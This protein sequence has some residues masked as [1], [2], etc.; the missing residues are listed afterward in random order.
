VTESTDIDDAVAF[1]Q[2]AG[3]LT[4]YPIPPPDR[5]GDGT[6]APVDSGLVAVYRDPDGC[7]V[8]CQHA[9]GCVMPPLAVGVVAG[10]AVVAAGR[11][12]RWGHL[13][14]P[15]GHGPARV[16]ITSGVR[17][18]LDV[19]VLQQVGDER[20]VRQ[21][22]RG[23]PPGSAVP[24]GAAERF[25]SVLAGGDRTR[26]A[27]HIVT[28]LVTVSGGPR[29]RIEAAGQ[30]L[31]VA[32]AALPVEPRRA[33]YLGGA[34]ACR[35]APHLFADR[36][37]R[38]TAGPRATTYNPRSQKQLDVE[39]VFLDQNHVHAQ[40]YLLYKYAELSFDEIRGLFSSAGA[41]EWDVASVFEEAEESLL[42]DAS[43]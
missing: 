33:F 29:E 34:T 7:S 14:L 8:I 18:V 31:G 20:A 25:R 30:R 3:R 22:S 5:T 19:A 4:D 21:L 42:L 17:D 39:K 13:T 40:T 16:R 9:P 12:D 43:D 35:A 26:V 2:W 24:P 15:L 6:V 11:L 1:W 23:A 36:A 27:A 38:G 37:N 10:D 32:P 28:E 41:E